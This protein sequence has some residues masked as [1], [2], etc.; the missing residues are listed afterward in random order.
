MSAAAVIIYRQ[1]QFVIRFLEAGATSPATARSLD[2][3][4]MRTH[5][6][7]RRMARAGVFLEVSPDRWYLDTAGWHKFEQRQKRRVVRFIG[8]FAIAF[9][10]VLLLILLC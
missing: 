10:L 5:W 1:R 6:I 2:D 3:L 7:F 4:D 8:V 9:I